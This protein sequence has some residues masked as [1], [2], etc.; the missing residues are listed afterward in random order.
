MRRTAYYLER[1]EDQQTRLGVAMCRKPRPT[2]KIKELQKELEA[3]I[4]SAKAEGASQEQLDK[5]L[6]R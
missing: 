1:I 4:L 3:L 5:A 2:H 6:G